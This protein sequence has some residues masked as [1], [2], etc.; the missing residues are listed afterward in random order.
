MI[1]ALAGAIDA[2]DSYTQ[3]HTKRVTAYAVELGKA[4][5][6]TEA[7]LDG[8]RQGGTLHGIG[9][10]GIPD[11]IL[12]KPGK[13]SLEQF[14]IVKQHPVLG[15]NICSP[16]K[17]LAQTLPC[18]RW[19]HEKPNGLGYP[20]GLDSSTIPISAKIIAVADVYDA[21]TTKRSYKEAFTDI[22][23][24]EM[25]TEEA[26]KG[27]LDAELVRLFLEIRPSGRL[28]QSVQQCSAR[29]DEASRSAK[30]PSVGE[31]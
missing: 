5:G 1:F 21:L 28:P 22:V 30:P 9:K 8:L 25:L 17:S 13:L 31:G 29:G 4:T 2:K 18:I 19:H 26:K 24:L 11:L 14:N 27:G 3:G 7:E 10:I 20:D 15:F 16:L 6:C 23:A 12:N